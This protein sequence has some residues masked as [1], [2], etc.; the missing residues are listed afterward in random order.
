MVL[1]EISLVRAGGQLLAYQGLNS[2]Q[3]AAPRP[4][5]S[6]MPYQYRPLQ[7]TSLAL[8]RPPTSAG[9]VTVRGLMAP[10]PQLGVPPGPQTGV[11]PGPL[12][13]PNLNPNHA[14][15]AGPSVHMRPRPVVPNVAVSF[16]PLQGLRG[17]G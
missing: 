5:A 2:E 12:N 16:Q 9:P 6:A 10:R 11:P 3:Q 13:L 1:A 4:Q 14:P 7:P 8:V 17:F 15:A